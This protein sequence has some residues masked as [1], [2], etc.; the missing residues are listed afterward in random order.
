MIDLRVH[1]VFGLSARREF[2]CKREAG[3][4]RAGCLIDTRM[5]MSESEGG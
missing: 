1:K 2:N 5:C 3:D 4:D